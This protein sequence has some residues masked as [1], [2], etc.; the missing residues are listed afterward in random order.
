M[1]KELCGAKY[2]YYAVYKA[3]MTGKWDSY[4]CTRPKDH[5]GRHKQKIDD[6]DPQAM[7][8]WPNSKWSYEP[9]PFLGFDGPESNLK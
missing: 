7:F 8:S 5:E 6:S 2:Y 4:S 3:N 9:T 1:S